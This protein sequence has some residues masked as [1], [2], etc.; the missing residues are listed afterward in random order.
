MT[1]GRARLLWIGT[2]ACSSLV[3]HAQTPQQIIQQVVNTERAANQND[4]SLWI[5]LEETH[6]PK[7]HILQ[8]VAGT[9]Q[10]DVRRVL[11]KDGQ[12]LSEPRQQELIQRFLQDTRA[13]KKQVAEANHDN[14][15]VDDFL[16]LLPV[17]F[18]WTQTAATATTTS[19]HFEPAPNFHPP[20]RESRVFSSMRGDLVSDNQQHRIRSVRGHLI[21]DITFGG[22]I[23][24]KLK[25]SSSFAL[26]Q[27]QV[28]PSLWQLTAIHVHLEGN[29][30]LFK[31]VSL[32]QDDARSRF[33]SEPS[34]ITLEQAA[35]KIMSRPGVMPPQAR[36]ASTAH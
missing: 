19:L 16:K 23:L 17:A 15:Q 18:L 14:Q 29:A 3:A 8:W 6:K 4:H 21:H 11:E 13:Q 9:Q 12:E 28:S 27:E 25:E 32:Q 20:T 34:T 5:Y 10:G 1:N 35:T 31:S 30:L 7:E 24:G 26:E 33:E 36:V 22:G 2:L